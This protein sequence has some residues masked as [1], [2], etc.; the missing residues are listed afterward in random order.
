METCG[1]CYW[2]DNGWCEEHEVDV[3]DEEEACSDWDL[4]DEV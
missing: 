2:N 1:N 4:N 3:N